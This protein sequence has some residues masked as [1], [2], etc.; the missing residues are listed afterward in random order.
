VFTNVSDVVAPS[1]VTLADVARHA[2]SSPAA[3]SLALRGRPGVSESTR[4]RILDAAA[5]VGYSARPT[6][7]D[8][9]ERAIAVLIASRDG[10]AAEDSYGIVVDAINL[11]AATQRSHVRLATLPIDDDDELADSALL[12]PT[13]GVDGYLVIAP[14]LSREA[15]PLFGG[16]PVVLVDGDTDNWD[17]YS[18]VVADDAAGASAA[19][20]LLVAFGHRRIVFAGTSR[21]APTPIVERRRGYE[22]AMEGAG[23][24]PAFVEGDTRDPDAVA[25]RAVEAITDDHHTA[26]VAAHDVIALATVSALRTVRLQVPDDVSVIGFGNIPAASMGAPKLTTIDVE[27]AAM[28]R[29][30]H[31]LLEQRILRPDDP[32]CT[33]LQRTR[34]VRHDTVGPPAP[35]RRR[36]AIR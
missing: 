2:R 3:V 34:L 18:T 17:A 29:L 21:G 26:V 30:A 19:T 23:L 24:E 9:P 35:S 32:P 7:T 25:A 36:R 12:V 11:V 16:R 20:A 27:R 14:W 1:R 5:A 10:R 28:G 4:R 6:A 15:A 22:E 8:Q 13:A 33:V 31:G